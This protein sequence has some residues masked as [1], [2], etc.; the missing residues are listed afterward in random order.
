MCGKMWI[1]SFL[2]TAS[3]AA[4]SGSSSPSVT[5]APINLSSCAAQM[6]GK[7][8][9]YQPL[10]FNFSGAIRR[11]YVAA[12]VETWNYAPSGWSPFHS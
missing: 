7:L 11:Y 9:Y 8:P 4:V 6:D 10:G 2:I 1:S 12:E 5:S 3:A